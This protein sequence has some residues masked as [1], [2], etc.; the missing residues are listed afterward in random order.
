MALGNKV[1]RP[2]RQPLYSAISLLIS[3]VFM[4]VAVAVP[5][6]SSAMGNLKIAML[7]IGIGWEF[8]SALLQVVLGLQT[9]VRAADLGE[10]LGCLSLIIM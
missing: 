2:S 10:R 4:L 1:G 7:Y 9:P 5:A 8:A 3:I 6:S